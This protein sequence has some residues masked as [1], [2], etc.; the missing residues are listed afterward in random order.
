M[1]LPVF[2]LLCQRFMFTPE[3]R[4][5]LPIFSNKFLHRI[6]SKIKKIF[7][8][9]KIFYLYF[10]PITTCQVFPLWQAQ[11]HRQQDKDH[12]SPSKSLFGYAQCS[13]R[14]FAVL[15]YKTAFRDKPTKA[16]A[17]THLV[18][19]LLAVL[20]LKLVSYVEIFG[21][22]LYLVKWHSFQWFAKFDCKCKR[23]NNHQW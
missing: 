4:K 20:M 12:W 22:S 7:R 5:Y 11:S 3:N 21:K 23:C 2:L 6:K 1:D 10:L 8:Q 14:F 9:L 15:R 16:A 19:E 17:P 13:R 18:R